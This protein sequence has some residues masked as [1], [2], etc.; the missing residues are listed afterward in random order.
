MSVGFH[1]V[2]EQAPSIAALGKVALSALR[3]PKQGSAVPPLPGPWI[4][5]TLAPRSPELIAAF[6]RH[7][8][9]D[10]SRYRGMVPAFLFPQWA[11][12][13][14]ART[15]VDLP[16]PLVRVINAGCNLKVHRPLPSGKPLR[17]KVRLDSVDDDGRRAILTTRVI[18]GTAEVPEALEAELRALVPLKKGDGARQRPTV[19]QDARELAFLRLRRDA[20]LDFALLTGDFNPIHIVPAYA[21]AAGFRSCILHGFATLARAAVA[22]EQGVLA[23]EPRNLVELDARFTRPLPLPASV[24]V[25]VQGESVWVGDAPGGGAY[26]EGRF[27]TRSSNQKEKLS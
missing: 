11:F 25:Y 3:P 18:T 19:P 10:P 16:Y 21:R 27:A 9:A 23:G 12:P 13:L 6:L 2:F 17:V 5:E 7:L 22:L 20:G 24:G 4:E 14:M 1:Y 15:L 8:G 26:L